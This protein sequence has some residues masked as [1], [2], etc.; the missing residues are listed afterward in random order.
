MKFSGRTHLRFRYNLH[1]FE[2]MKVQKGIMRTQLPS[3]MDYVNE[4]EG[5]WTENARFSLCSKIK[6]K[7]FEDADGA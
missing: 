7:S 3:L 4:T 2:F 6:F 1:L 5:V